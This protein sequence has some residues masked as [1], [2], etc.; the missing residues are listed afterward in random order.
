MRSRNRGRRQSAAL[1]RSHTLVSHG[2]CSAPRAPV[3][4]RTAR[5]K[6]APAAPCMLARD[7]RG[8][9][10]AGASG[11]CACYMRMHCSRRTGLLECCRIRGMHWPA[12]RTMYRTHAHVCA[13]LRSCGSCLSAG[14]V[15]VCGELALPDAHRSQTLVSCLTRLCCASVTSALLRVR[16]IRQ[17][18]RAGGLG[19]SVCMTAL[20]SCVLSECSLSHVLALSDL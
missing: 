19:A 5:Y 9:L 13:V 12:L 18:G 10:S 2:T 7:G 8:S 4:V 20:A 3:W 15:R 1:S 6:H 14:H 16:A 11:A 17:S